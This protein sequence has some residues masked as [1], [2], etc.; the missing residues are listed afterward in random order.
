MNTLMERLTGFIS[1][2][3]LQ[4]MMDGL[5]EVIENIEAGTLNSNINKD[6]LVSALIELENMIGLENPKKMIVKQV[7]ALIAGMQFKNS[8]LNTVI[9]G[10]PGVGKSDLGRVLANIWSS[11]GLIQGADT[12]K[13]CKQCGCNKDKRKGNIQRHEFINK[14]Q[15]MASE[16]VSDISK[17]SREP[18]HDDCKIKYRSLCAERLLTEMSIY[19]MAV[20]DHDLMQ[21]FDNESENNN[22][23]IVIAHAEDFIGEYVG[24]TGPKTESFIK[25]HT[26]KVILIDEC[27]TLLQEHYGREALTVINRYISENVKVRKVIF[28]FAGYDD[29]VEQLYKLQPGLK[30]RCKFL[31]KI[32]KYSPEEIA[33][34]FIKQ[35]QRTDMTLDDTSVKYLKKFFEGKMH[36]FPSFG[37]STSNLIYDL[38]IAL[39]EQNYKLMFDKR[40]PRK[41]STSRESDELETK[42]TVS[43]PVIN[44]AFE[45]YA[46]G[47]GK[48]DDISH[49][50]MYR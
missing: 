35:V 46:Q 49:L 5:N 10:P 4:N 36:Q 43:I 33:D 24:H 6:L 27:Y 17:Y 18:E 19:D 44:S 29:L 47:L 31:L 40:R 39:G 22:G 7:M 15:H 12:E 1:Y 30:R 21:E 14:V 13:I 23:S 38:E 37:G 28:I 42:K 26:G 9:T 2:L 25:K 34:I 48:T 41:S 50:M 16:C 3:I 8:F 11:M 45:S 32:E 20:E